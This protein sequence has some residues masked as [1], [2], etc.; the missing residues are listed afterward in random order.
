MLRF[1]SIDQGVITE[2]EPAADTPLT[3]AIKNA[4]WIDTINPTEEE[5]QVLASTLNI[6]LPGADDVEEIEA[7]SRCFIDHEG[8]HVHALFMSPNEGRFNT[9]PWLVCYKTTAC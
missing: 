9:V 2:T 3:I 8:L 6:T 7:S 1:F 4:H 5:R